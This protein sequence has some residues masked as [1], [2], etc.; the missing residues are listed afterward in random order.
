MKVTFN[1]ES[2]LGYTPDQVKGITLGEL[3]AQVEEAVM[4]WGEDTEVVLHQINNRYGANYG[5][6]VEYE[7]F[8]N[9]DTVEDDE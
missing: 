1:V 6:F 3:M 8:S 4:E 2:N 5:R 7:L 9:E